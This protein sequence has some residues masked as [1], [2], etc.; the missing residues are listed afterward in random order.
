M[1]V[2]DL[3]RTEEYERMMRRQIRRHRAL[4]EDLGYADEDY[5]VQEYVLYHVLGDDEGFR[6]TVNALAVRALAQGAVE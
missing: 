4:L 1:P 5:D 6:S 2:I 3:T